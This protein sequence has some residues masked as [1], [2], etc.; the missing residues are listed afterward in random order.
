MIRCQMNCAGNNCCRPRSSEEER[1]LRDGLVTEHC[2]EE[3]GIDAGLEGHM[4]AR[5]LHLWE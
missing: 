3:V 5:D 1:V 2:T 4:H